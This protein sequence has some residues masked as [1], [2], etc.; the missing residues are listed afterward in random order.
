MSI[1]AALQKQWEQLKTR[2]DEIQG[3]LW[4]L[5]STFK[6]YSIAVNDL[7]QNEW[8]LDKPLMV[9]VEQHGEEDFIACFYD[10]DVYGYGDSIPEALDDLKERL[11]NQVEFLLAEEKQVSLG[12]VP[13]KQLEVLLHH[14]KRGV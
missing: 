2:M 12:V 7:G 3:E 9:T 8:R 14:I 5:R 11:V 6:V 10:A 1:E 4:K 13:Q